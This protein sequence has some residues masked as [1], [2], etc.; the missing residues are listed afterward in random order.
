MTAPLWT[1]RFVVLLLAQIGVAYA[2]SSFLILPKFLATRLDAGPEAIGRVVLVSSLAL[3]VCL[4]PAGSLVDRHGRKRFLTAG[5]AAMGFACAG[6]VFVD[7]IGP[8]LYGLRVVQ[9][10]AFAFAY[11]SGAALTIDAAPPTRLGQALGLFGIVYVLTGALAP[12]AVE[13]IVEAAGWSPAFLLA[14]AAALVSALLSLSVVERRVEAP[15][16]MHVATLSILARPSVR[17]AM[18]VVGLLGVGYGG[19]F[20]FHQPFALSLGITE[21]RDFFLGH[22]LAAA[23]SRLATGPFVD[24]IGLRRISLGS[25]AL[26]ALAVLA[27]AWL[28]RFGL[29][30]VGIGM[31]VSHGLFYPAY[32]GVVLEGC[33]PAERGRYIA[34]MQAGLY[35]GIGVGGA[36]LGVIAARY[37][38]PVVFVL[39]AVLIGVALALI[40]FERPGEEG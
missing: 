3:V 4:L 10:F 7:S 30:L 26:Y 8:L 37:G 6:H 15:G 1:R 16:A 32:T 19:A 12:A 38:Y 29:L 25:L 31:G 22:S 18:A 24:R 21:L 36:A 17:R 14:G 5:A 39:G 35:V 20:N 40:A 2:N 34:L 9:A 33:P 28:D 11:A 27:I 13:A 23:A